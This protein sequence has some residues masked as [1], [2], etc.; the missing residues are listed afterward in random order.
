MSGRLVFLVPVAV[1]ALGGCAT[2]APPPAAAPVVPAAPPGPALPPVL[3]EAI[4]RVKSLIGDPNDAAI[5]ASFS[6][7]FLTSVSPEKVKAVL[8]ATNAQVGACKAHRAEQVKNDFG[9]AAEARL[10]CE[11]GA[12]NAS[13]VV[14]PA[15]PHLIE[16]LLLKPAP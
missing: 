8:S 5:K 14:N 12:I 7:T 6:P 1:V 15:P 4:G 16:G 13:I 9:W 2:E 10:Q 11:R 3:E